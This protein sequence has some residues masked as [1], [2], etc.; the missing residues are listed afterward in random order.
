MNQVYIISFFDINFL[1][2]VFIILYKKIQIANFNNFHQCILWFKIF[3]VIT[4][5]GGEKLKN[6]YKDKKRVI[7]KPKAVN[8][9]LIVDINNT[10]LSIK[11]ISINGKIIDCFTINN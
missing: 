3:Q 6:K 1:I 8:H 5:G 10:V 4:G 7:V 2:N 11:A 9:F